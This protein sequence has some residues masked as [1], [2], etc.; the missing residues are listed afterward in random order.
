MSHSVACLL[1]ARPTRHCPPPRPSL[2]TRSR[3]ASLYQRHNTEHDPP[4]WR[5]AIWVNVNYLA[6]QVG[7]F[8]ESAAGDGV[9]VHVAGSFPHRER[10]W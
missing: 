5:G 4:Y 10:A 9:G 3:S 1:G 8:G 2:A 6:V 7:N